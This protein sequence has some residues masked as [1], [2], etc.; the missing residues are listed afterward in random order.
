ML[1]AIQP[2]QRGQD[3]SVND[4]VRILQVLINI[5]AWDLVQHSEFTHCGSHGDGGKP[6]V[7]ITRCTENVLLCAK[8][9]TLRC[10]LC[11]VSPLWVLYDERCR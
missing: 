10:V 7:H 5:C 2:L 9:S 8:C 6:R 3:T 4:Q 11:P 1:T